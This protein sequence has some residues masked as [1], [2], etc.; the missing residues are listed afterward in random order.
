M[1]AI[2]LWLRFKSGFPS[3][4]ISSIKQIYKKCEFI[5]YDNAPGS[6]FEVRLSQDLMFLK[7]YFTFALKSFF[8]T[9]FNN[10]IS[11]ADFLFGLVN[12]EFK[13]VRLQQTLTDL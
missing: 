5:C 10:S 1:A 3:T 7:F 2:G 11:A 12:D 9:A 13:S 4:I 6:N 8:S